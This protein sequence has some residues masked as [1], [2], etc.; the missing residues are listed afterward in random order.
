MKKWDNRGM[1]RG[2]SRRPRGLNLFQFQV[3]NSE[4]LCLVISFNIMFLQMPNHKCPKHDVQNICE[5]HWIDPQ[6]LKC[7]GAQKCIALLQSFPWVGIAMKLMAIGWSMGTILNIHANRFTFFCK[8]A[9]DLCKEDWKIVTCSSVNVVTSVYKAS[10]VQSSESFAKSLKCIVPRI[11]L[12]EDQNKQMSS[13]AATHTVLE[14]LDKLKPC[15]DVA[16][17]TPFFSEISKPPPW[18][19]VVNQHLKWISSSR[20]KVRCIQI[21]LG[22]RV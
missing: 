19:F 2:S 16:S 9:Y 20:L 15:S 22:I 7:C 10:S 3:Q 21:C 17:T 8:M 12:L 13:I 4:C 18:S 11:I 5:F 14:S 1:R 6:N